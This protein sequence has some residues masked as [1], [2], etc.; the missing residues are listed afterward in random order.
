MAYSGPMVAVIFI[1]VESDIIGCR[2]ER[3]RIWSMGG[4][5][6]VSLPAEVDVNNAHLL[7]GALIHACRE[8]G[9]V[10]VV[11]MTATTFIDARVI[12]V[13]AS[14]RKRMHDAG[15]ELRLVVRSAKLLR[16]LRVT[17][18]DRLFRIFPN[19]DEAVTTDRPHQ[20][21]SARAA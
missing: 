16:L 1:P 10:V 12:G 8:G 21:P 11:D 3:C 2:T 20:E 15:G 4:L 19:L 6:V 14:L 18:Q 17:H 7:R 5:P 9:P 13:L